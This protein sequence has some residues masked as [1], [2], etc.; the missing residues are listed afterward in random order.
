MFSQIA[1][2]DWAELSGS[3]PKGRSHLGIQKQGVRS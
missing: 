3:F 1:A 2:S